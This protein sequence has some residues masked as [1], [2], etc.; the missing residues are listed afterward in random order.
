MQHAKHWWRLCYASILVLAG[1]ANHS[2]LADTAHD[3]AG[4]VSNAC[5]LGATSI[6]LT[7]TRGQ[8]NPTQIY[9]PSS[10]SIGCNKTGGTLSISST[11][12]TSP[13]QNPADYTLTVSGWGSNA[14]YDTK[15]LPAPS[16]TTNNN[17]QSTNISFSG[18]IK[19]SDLSVGTGGNPNPSYTATIT[20]SMSMSIAQ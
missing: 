10:V 2:A 17:V 20:L 11:R 13:G 3:V 1:A 19:N 5:S 12:L 4:T 7:A 6:I 16:Q 8:N 14:S 18:N 9:T 15:N